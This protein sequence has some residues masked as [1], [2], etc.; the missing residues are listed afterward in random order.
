VPTKKQVRRKRT[1]RRLSPPGQP[2]MLGLVKPPC[3]PDGCDGQL[4]LGVYLDQPA[5]VSVTFGA[6]KGAH[7]IQAGGQIRALPAGHPNTIN[8]KLAKG[9]QAVHIPVD[10]NTPD[11]PAIE[12]VMVKTGNA[13]A[14]IF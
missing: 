3:T 2:R 5:N 8:F 7:R 9:D 13:S 12:S 6:T 4:Q 11:G 14:R 10:W 1:A